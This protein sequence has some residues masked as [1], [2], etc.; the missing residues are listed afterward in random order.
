MLYNDGTLQQDSY[1]YTK[2]W[3]SSKNLH[4][5]TPVAARSKVWVCG[6]SL[7]RIVGLNLGEDMDVSFLWMLCVVRLRNL[8][9]P[10]PRPLSYRVWCVSVCCV[11]VC[12]VC[13]VSVSVCGVSV[14]VVSVNVVCL[15][16]VCLC[17]VCLCVW[18]VCVCGVCVWCCDVCGVSVCV[19]C[20]CVWCVSVC[21]GIDLS[22]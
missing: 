11:S 22:I 5:P 16:V 1:T 15:C 3:P 4:L 14:C 17:V 13:G 7:A 8:R 18:C 19:A 20:L 6:C 21:V 2:A 12:V 9:R 10:I